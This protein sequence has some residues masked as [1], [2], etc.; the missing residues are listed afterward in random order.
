[1][2]PKT[3][4]QKYIIGLSSTIKEP[5][6]DVIEHANKKHTKYVALAYKQN[7][8]CLECGYNWKADQEPTKKKGKCDCPSCDSTL[9]LSRNYS[10]GY[11]ERYYFGVI[12]TALDC[13][14]VRVFM[15]TKRYKKNEKPEHHLNEVIRHFI[16]PKGDTYS[17]TKP[18]N[19]MGMYYDSW[20]FGD[21]EFRTNTPKHNMRLNLSLSEIYPNKKVLPILKRNGFKSSFKGL[22]PH[23]LFAVLLRDNNAETYFKLNQVQLLKALM[24]DVKLSKFE[25]SIRIALKH[26]YV[27]KDATDYFDYL[28]LLDFFG[29]DLNSPK[30]ICPPNFN[31]EHDL[32]VAKKMKLDD[33]EKLLI[34]SK[35]YSEQFRKLK[36]KYF[37]LKLV[38]DNITI[39]PLKSI[40]EF[41]E[42][43]TELG[44]C[45]YSRD[46]FKKSN[47]LVL[48][49]KVNGKRKE[50]VEISLK[51]FS[52]L[53]SRGKC[54]VPSKYNA[55]IQNI[56]NNNMNQ[57]VSM[58]S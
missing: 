49:A 51:D 29:K 15:S 46:Y 56:V 3:K 53:Q 44:H 52:I 30:F 57:I 24:N 28:S 35:K 6:K 22:Q 54:N 10:G 9:R 34:T 39:E 19:G 20:T 47:T 42:E 41:Y 26:N 8:F 11:S 45:I 38:S 12:D 21:L 31:E 16:S 2:K 40:E 18:V 37:S 32:L 36:A 27:I 43:A 50:T 58:A 25:N 5:N 14:V 4:I 33:I 17:I 1:M 48:S 23:K 7:H 55:Q 13:Q